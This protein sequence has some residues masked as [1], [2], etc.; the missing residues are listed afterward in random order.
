MAFEHDDGAARSSDFTRRS[1]AGH[2][3]ADD[4][5]VYGFADVSLFDD[6]S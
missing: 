6:L 5:D 4:D 3:T 2:A 1:Q